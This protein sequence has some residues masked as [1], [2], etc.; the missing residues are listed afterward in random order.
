MRARYLAGCDGMNSTVRTTEGIEFAGAR[1]PQTFLL[2]DLEVDGLEAGT[3]NAFLTA[4]G[5]LLFFPLDRPAPWRVIAMRADSE[6]GDDQDAVL[7]ELQYLTE[8][9]SNG[10]LRL[11]EPVW[12]SAFRIQHRAAR[13]YRRGRAFL[14]GDAAHVHSPVGA[15]GM[16]T[17]MQDAVNVAWKLALVCRDQA[18]PSLLA[19]YDAERRP[20][21]E[22]V[23]KFTDRAFSM[24]TSRQAV[25]QLVRARV[26][27]RLLPLA[28]HLRPGR[29][30]A[31]RTVSQLGV[32]YRSSPAVQA[33][34]TASRRT[35]RP[36]DRLPDAPVVID[37][38]S[39]WLQTE[40][41][42]PAFHLL[43][44]GPDRWDEAAV[45]ALEKRYAGVLEVVRLGRAP[46]RGVLY[47]PDGVALRRLRVSDCATLLVRPDGY[48]AT[49]AMTQSSTT[50]GDTCRRGCADEKCGP[51]EAD[52]PWEGEGETDPEHRLHWQEREGD[53][54]SG[55]GPSPHQPGCVRDNDHQREEHD[56]HHDEEIERAVRPGTPY[57]GKSPTNHGR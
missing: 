51:G 33:G 50:R 4:A 6:G 26:A 54:G 15:Q 22:Y 19:S 25:A 35:P 55:P 12:T 52:R 34:A 41:G 42:A 43:L 7:S 17:G 32:R 29:S 20:V 27:P 40:L 24:A 44:C 37:G 28:L 3:V 57:I 8:I 14:A 45:T 13:Q 53:D 21:G 23:L 38:R 11:H 2:A 18:H 30:V 47:T 49:R 1:Y 5:P 9:A 39:S 31:F 48:L 10:R 16:N 36:G 56:Q 46:T